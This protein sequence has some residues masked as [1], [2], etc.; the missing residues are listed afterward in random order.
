MKKLLTILA[1]MI[2]LAACTPPT[3]SPTIT[4]PSLQTGSPTQL[5]Q[6]PVPPQPSNSMVTIRLPVGYIPNIQFAPIYV[7]MDKGFYSS[8][9]LEV[10][11]D[12]STEI[13]SVA[14]VGA[15]NLSFAVVSGEQVLLG[16]AQ[17]LPIVYV[18]NW[19]SKYPVAIAALKS[20]GINQPSDLKGKKI[21]T[22]VLSGASY[23]GLTALLK[24]GGL[25]TSD[26]KLDTIGF[27]QVETLTSGLDDAVVVYGPNEPIQLRALGYDITEL[28]VSDYLELV[29]NGLISNEKYIQ[30]HP[31]IVK[32][33]VAATLEGIQYTIAHPD[34][35]YQ[36]STR[37]VEN[38]A[39]T[40]QAVQKQVLASSIELWQN[41]QPG[42]SNPQAW[43]NMADLL[44]EMNLLTTA[45]DVSKAYSNDFLP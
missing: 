10:I 37:Y 32:K 8:R 5:S 20:T 23:I 26:V 41:P 34:E 18:M 44:V 36:I 4:P 3:A 40:D 27:T 7:A 1:T 30:E 16:R 28:K 38:L 14:L 15:G 9:G 17:Q 33:M 25:M 22:P 11:M 13:D 42:F 35:A 12:Y 45:P 19:Y 6:S 43:Q 2:L 24:A 31:G 21:G 39:K 29:G